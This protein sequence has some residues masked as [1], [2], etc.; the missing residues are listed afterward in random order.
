MFTFST[1]MAAASIAIVGLL[2]VV[3]YQFLNSGHPLDSSNWLHITHIGMFSAISFSLSAFLGLIHEVPSLK[4]HYKK[5]FYYGMILTFSIGWIILFYI[6]S[7]L[8]IQ[9]Y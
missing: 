7:I 5:F 8:F 2:L 9:T 3:T 6:F 4:E 1:Q